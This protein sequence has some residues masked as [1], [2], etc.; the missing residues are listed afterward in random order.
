MNSGLL[1]RIKF[2]IITPI[3]A[4]AN[5]QL[6]MITLSTRALS[7]CLRRRIAKVILRWFSLSCLK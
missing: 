5:M 4:V 6:T 2:Q 3:S 7:K 1:G